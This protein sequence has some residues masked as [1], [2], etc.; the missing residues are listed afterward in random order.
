MKQISDKRFG[1][2]EEIYALNSNTKPAMYLVR[3]GKVFIAKSNGAEEIIEPGGYFGH[4]NMKFD[5]EDATCSL[6]SSVVAKTSAVAEEET[7]CGILT[8]E[9]VVA[10]AGRVFEC[11]INIALED[12]VRHR[13]LGEGQFGTVWLVTDK[14]AID[15]SEP[16]A[17]KVQDTNDP[18]GDRPDAATEIKAE[19]EM[20]KCLQHPTIVKLYSWYEEINSI[21]MLLNLAPGGELFDIMHQQSESGRGYI[22]GIKEEHAKFY[23][24][25]IADALAYMHRKKF[26]YRDLKPENILI[27]KDGY[28]VLTDFGFSK[29]ISDINQLHRAPARSNIQFFTK[30]A[31][32]FQLK[33]LKTKHT[34]TVGHRYVKQENGQVNS[35]SNILWLTLL[36]LFRTMSHQR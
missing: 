36:V 2:D 27:D 1:E 12:L 7:V 8:L 14:N 22:S 11:P 19:I 23:A 35:C 29:F 17:L 16:M 6:P 9:D 25:G 31:Y 26:V 4:E 18:D 5:W 13:I 10:I 24:A 32:P 21:S 30:P 28:P 34:H 15:E 3:S 33:R 20:M